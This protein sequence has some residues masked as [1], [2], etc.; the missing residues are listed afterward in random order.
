MNFV[1]ILIGGLLINNYVFSRFLG[2]CPFVGLSRKLE[3]ATGMSMAVVFVMTVASAVSWL[4]Q[5]LILDPLGLGYLQTITFILVIASLVQLVEM[6]VQKLSPTLYQALG[7]YLPLITTNC[8][9]LGVAIL[10][11]QS[12]FTFAESVFNGFASALGWSLAILL[13]AGIRERL[14]LADVPEAMKGFPTALVGTGLMSL[15]FFGFQGLF[16]DLFIR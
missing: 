2:L 11:I 10:N 6:V 8:A 12:N 5:R 7:I 14:E 4:M 1:A 9:V 16:K 15:A 13:F 3:T